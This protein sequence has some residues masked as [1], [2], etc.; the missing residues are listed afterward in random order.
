MYL[1]ANI[2]VLKPSVLKLL[3]AYYSAFSAFFNY[4]PFNNLATI[5]SAPLV[6]IYIFPSGCLTI[7]DIRFLSELN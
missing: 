3:V 2:N 6:K 4:D 5:E 1:F 7:L